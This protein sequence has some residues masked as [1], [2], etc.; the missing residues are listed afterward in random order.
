MKATIKKRVF[1]IC[2]ICMCISF[3]SFS[4]IGNRSLTCSF[5][6]AEKGDFYMRKLN[7]HYY[8]GINPYLDIGAFSQFYWSVTKDE[9]SASAFIPMLGLSSRIG[10][11]PLFNISKSRFNIFIPIDFGLKLRVI[12]RVPSFP[13]VGI[14]FDYGLGAQFHL[15]KNIAVFGQITNGF[16]VT[17]RPYYTAGI[18]FVW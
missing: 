8:W 2:I 11:L 14:M 7:F 17:W 6:Q 1:Y 5:S 15:F 9:N 18:A 12:D 16:G 10:L 3:K 4:Q 13:L